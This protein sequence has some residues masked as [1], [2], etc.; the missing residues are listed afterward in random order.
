DPEAKP[1][2]AG[3]GETEPAALWLL[4]RD[5]GEARVVGTRPGGVRSPVVAAEA[6]TVLVTSMTMPGAITGEDDEQ[7]RA[8]RKD[9]KISA[10]LHS[11]YPVRYWD[12]D[13]GPDQPRL[14]AATPPAGDG[15][16]Q[17]TDLTPA[18]GAA[19]QETSAD[20]S[21][22]GSTVVTS[23]QVAE[24]HGSSRSTL[25]T[26]DLAG[27]EQRTLADDPDFEF[28]HPRISPDGHSVAVIRTTR[29]TPAEAPHIE[30]VV[31]PLTGGEPLVLTNGWDRWP[32]G[33]RWTPDSS[34]L[35]VLADEHGGAPLF[36]ITV[37]DG[38]VTRLTGDHGAYTDP[39]VAPDG[40]HVYAL[41]A[42]VDAPPAPVRLDARRPDQQPVLLAGPAQPP[43]LPGSLVETTT[44]AADGSSLRAWLALPVNAATEPAPLLLWIH[45]GPL[46]SWNSWAWRWNPWLMVARGYA[47]LLPDPALSTGYGRA[48]VNRGWGEWG[49]TPCADLLTFTDATE[50]LPEIDETRT[51]AM[52]GSFGGYMANWL[53]GHTDRFAAIVTHASIWSLDQASRTT[54]A[55]YYWLRE[56]TAEMMAANSPHAHADAIT[57][58]M[59]VI[60][61]DKDYRVPIGEALRLWWDLISGRPDPGDQPHRF[62]Y[63]PD[64]NHW[65]LQPQ[66]AALWYETVTA[67]LAHHVLGK[68]FEIPAL[69]R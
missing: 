31:L 43:A 14:L 19:L 36:R 57:T 53:A 50:A 56:M 47:V 29:P 54:D 18:P 62:L 15:A 13:L 24:P 67:F 38:T 32:T 5:G 41:R 3:S 68:E 16:V 59:L 58:P 48:F 46:F 25:I 42:A 23:W 28:E 6:G 34:A 61:G 39:Q 17:W 10:V 33:L 27:G 44:T 30:L 20:I 49:T 7:R 26:I 66:H 60:H 64:E 8:A 9:K 12:H 65:I 21:S 69:L 55:A 35:I 4:P 45:G 37:P 51:A 40:R 63:F 52:G 2:E 11:G 1:K 22:D